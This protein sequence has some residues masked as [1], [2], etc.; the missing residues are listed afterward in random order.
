MVNITR[1]CLSQIDLQVHC[2][3]EGQ[4]LVLRDVGQF[5]SKSIVLTVMYKQS[6]LIKL[7]A[8]KLECF[9][10]QPPISGKTQHLHRY[11]SCVSA[12]VATLALNRRV[13]SE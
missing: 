7:T 4:I 8:L 10:T 13:E 11:S 2:N 9:N 5:I 1:H 12:L 6:E 3:S